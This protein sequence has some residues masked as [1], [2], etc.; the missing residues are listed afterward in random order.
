M[1]PEDGADPLSPELEEGPGYEASAA[2]K[3]LPACR[4]SPSTRRSRLLD[5]EQIGMTLSDG[6]AV[7]P[8]QSTGRRPPPAVDRQY[9]AGRDTHRALIATA[10][11]IRGGCITCWA[12]SIRRAKTR[13]S[14][15]IGRA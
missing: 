10:P 5:L 3:G 4:T 7:L 12:A 9:G 15:E 8:E 14:A 11:G 13:L 1:P 6:Y 2:E